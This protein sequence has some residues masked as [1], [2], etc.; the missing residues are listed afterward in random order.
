MNVFPNRE[1]IDAVKKTCAQAGVEY[2][3]VQDRIGGGHDVLFNCPEVWGTITLPLEK[4][5][6]A[7]ISA[8]V[9]KQIKQTERT[10]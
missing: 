5:N 10:K 2:V 8:A 6:A 3:G 1:V 4:F 9:A 7:A